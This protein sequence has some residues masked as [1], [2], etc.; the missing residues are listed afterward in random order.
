M[1]P[2]EEAGDRGPRYG[3]QSNLRSTIACLAA[4]LA[5]CGAPISGSDTWIVSGGVSVTTTDFSRAVT[6]IELLLDQKVVSS[7]TGPPSGYR[8]VSFP[9]QELIYG[10]SHKLQLRLV[11]QVGTRVTYRVLASLTMRTGSS[12]FDITTYH[13]PYRTYT[14]DAGDVVD[15]AFTVR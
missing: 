12:A 6:S 5:A 2:K 4:G 3:A 13:W 1:K 14:L 9:G 7:A 10:S 15:F 11:G 8:A